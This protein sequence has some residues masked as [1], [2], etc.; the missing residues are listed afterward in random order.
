MWIIGMVLLSLLT[1]LLLGPLLGQA[2]EEQ[3]FDPDR[4]GLPRDRRIARN[5]LAHSGSPQKT[6][7]RI[8]A[9]HLN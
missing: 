8:A 3:S 7:S 2:A 4:I 9:A 1:G 5:R 6:H